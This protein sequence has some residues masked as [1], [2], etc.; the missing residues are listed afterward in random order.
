MDEKRIIEMMC[1]I[2]AYVLGKLNQKEIDDLWIEFLKEPEWLGILEVE[3]LLRY[4]GKRQRE[5]S[6]A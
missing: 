6:N 2:E 1:R 4:V 3:I 5:A